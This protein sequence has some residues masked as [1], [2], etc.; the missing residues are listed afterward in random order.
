M[1]TTRPYSC[2]WKASNRRNRV[3]T[4]GA[5]RG[6]RATPPP[7]VQGWGKYEIVSR[8]AG[9]KSRSARA[10]QTARGDE[11]GQA[12]RGPIEGFRAFTPGKYETVSGLAGR[13]AAAPAG[14]KHRGD[15]PRQAPR[16]NQRIPGLYAGANT[17]SFRVWPTEKN[18]RP[19]LS[20][21]PATGG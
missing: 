2:L 9:R 5:G 12:P 15:G 18:R 7:G 6:T 10:L 14:F 17:K 19:T 20:N 8:L 1:P 4:G 3:L 21:F 16:A 13:K 11:P